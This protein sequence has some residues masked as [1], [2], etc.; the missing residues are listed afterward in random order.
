MIFDY[1]RTSPFTQRSKLR[2]LSK[3]Q[4]KSNEGQTLIL[5]ETVFP[6]KNNMS[7]VKG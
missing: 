4:S 7:N 3:N 2:Q 5:T 1:L 6:Q